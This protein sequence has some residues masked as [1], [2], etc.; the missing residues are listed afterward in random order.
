[1][2][3]VNKVLFPVDLSEVSPKIVPQVQMMVGQFNAQ[4]HLVYV[5]ET[6]EYSAGVYGPVVGGRDF[7]EDLVKSAEKGLEDFERQHF[8]GYSNTVRAVL[9]GDPAEELLNYIEAHKID[10]V[11]MGTHGRKGL[12]KIIFGSVADHVVKNASVP[13]LTV[14]PYR[15]A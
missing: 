10:M 14:N 12:D 15:K 2:D 1:M 8:S 7:E 4:I 5:A 11:I 6:L 9:R 13:V 3:K